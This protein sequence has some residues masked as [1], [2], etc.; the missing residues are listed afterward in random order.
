[1]N[2]KILFINRKPKKKIINYKIKLKY[3]NLIFI[4]LFIFL[5]YIN[6][7]IRTKNRLY[8]YKTIKNYENLYNVSNEE[9]NE[10]HIIN[11][12]NILLD[13]NKY[14]NNHP[15]ISVVLT[16]F[17][18]DHC[19][20][21]ALRSIQ[22]Q[23]VKNLEIIIVDDCSSDNSLKII[24]NY[25]KEDKRIIIIQHT[26]NEGKIKSRSD[27]I[28]IARG[29]YITVLDGDD[30]FIH[31]DILKNGLIIAF[32]G[33]LDVVEFQIIIFR[34]GK[35]IRCLNRYGI[36]IKK[37]VYQP[38]LSKKFFLINDN[39]RYRAMRNRNICGKIIKK[40]IFRKVINYIGKKYIEDYIL[41]YEDTMMTVSLFQIAKSYYYMKEQGYYYSKDDKK[42]M[43]IKKCNCTTNFKPGKDQ[44]KFVQ[45]L[46]EKLKNNKIE[47]Q[48]IYHEIMSINHY[49]KFYRFINQEH[50]FKMVYNVFDYI[51]KSRFILDYQKQKL[52]SLK[53][54]L[55]QKEKKLKKIKM[56]SQ[57]K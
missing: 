9:I 28:M 26:I 25:Q 43:L 41:R 54:R 3:I 20:H 33:D 4:N 47:R 36:K 2:S 39:D 29:K 55:L 57:K 23:S 27:G 32:L 37:I 8:I 38:E 6:N 22:N 52:I 12:K 50:D 56:L 49:E 21:K 18:Q 16:I 13:R 48:F 10:F 45:F 1:M 34:K 53:I 40:D 31:K 46:I 14:N 42:K 17:N 35:L 19:V 44:V 15:D 51:L 30:A 7:I 11:S 24:K 5:F